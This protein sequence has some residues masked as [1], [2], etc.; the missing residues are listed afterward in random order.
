MSLKTCSHD[1]NPTSTARLGAHTA[2]IQPVGFWLAGIS[3]LTASI[4]CAAWL[5]AALLLRSFQFLQLGDDGLVFE[6]ASNCVVSELTAQPEC[7]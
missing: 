3:V 6:V 2:A 4:A 1:F 7:L 5:P